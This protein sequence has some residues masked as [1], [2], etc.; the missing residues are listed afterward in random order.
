MYIQID[1]NIVKRSYMII[2]KSNFVNLQNVFV[3]FSSKNIHRLKCCLLLRFALS[4]KGLKP[5]GAL[6]IFSPGE[7]TLEILLISQSIMWYHKMFL[8]KYLWK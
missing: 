4:L 2:F 5:G 6:E 3:L 7:W 8:Y 1:C